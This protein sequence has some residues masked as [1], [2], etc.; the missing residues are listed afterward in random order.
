M[1]LAIISNG[2]SG[3]EYA[4]VDGYH[5]TV[6]GV[7]KQVGIYECTWW[8]F[9]DFETYRDVKPKGRPL[10]FTK[11]PALDNLKLYAAD[12][13]ADFRRQVVQWHE[14]VEVPIAGW[15][16]FSG[17]AALGLALHLDAAEVD[18]FGYDMA[19]SSDCTGEQGVSRTEPRWERERGIFEGLVALMRA[20]GRIVRH[21]GAAT[22]R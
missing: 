22:C 7:N 20:Q 3:S 2:P 14:A 11:Q 6:I 5:D 17:V 12:R 13:V 9:C 18:L 1:K 10:I 8:C 4:K 21:Y 19:G 15:H 16:N